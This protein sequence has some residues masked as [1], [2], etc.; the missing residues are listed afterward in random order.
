MS[1]PLTPPVVEDRLR[2]LVNGIATAQRELAQ[3]RRAEVDAEVALRRARAIAWHDPDVPRVTRGGTTTAERDAWIDGRVEDEWVTHRIAVTAREI[4]QDG[5]RAVL[6]Q[7]EV[8]R[9]LS[10]SVRASYELA[11]HS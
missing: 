3:A 11:N 6:A 1:E 2:Q 10:A 7:A 5:L 9:S 8:V 4:G